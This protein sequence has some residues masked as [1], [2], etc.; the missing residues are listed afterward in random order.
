MKPQ[1]ANLRKL[2]ALL[3]ID[4][5]LEPP[6]SGYGK[7]H[8][9]AVIM[10]L[11]EL[12]DGDIGVILTKRTE[13]LKSHPGQISF[14]GGKVDKED[15]NFTHT[16]LRE[17]VEETG[18]KAENLEVLGKYKDIIT[19]TGYHITPIVAIYH[20]EGSFNPCP[21]EVDFIFTL[22]YSDF[23]N[24]PFY[25]IEG[26]EAYEKH[27]YYLDHPRGILWGAT[28]YML[29][30]FFR[31]YFGF[32]RKPIIAEPNLNVPPFFDPKKL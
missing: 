10:A 20:G 14:P 5:G 16:A 18:E 32:D 22:K 24:Y 21:R 2:K 7:L 19:R 3:E 29:V 8:S 15:I 1:M 12:E 23:L 13:H 26:R 17:W 25:S 11:T 6:P 30:N 27:I 31:E 9:S 4:R 28:A